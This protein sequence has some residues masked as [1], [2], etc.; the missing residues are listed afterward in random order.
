M[1]EESYQPPTE[2]VV[3]EGK[4]M[5]D[6]LTVQELA[7]VGRL[8][9]CDPYEAVADTPLDEEGRTRGIRWLA[10]AHCAWVWTRRTDPSAKLAPFLELQPGD[11]AKLTGW[12]DEVDKGKRRAELL[13]QAELSDEERD[14]LVRLEAELHEEDDPT[15]HARE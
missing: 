6:D 5:L 15:V 11:V 4:N 14:E 1:T 3:P 7:I 2:R 13:A 12:G 9:K 8:L 10:M